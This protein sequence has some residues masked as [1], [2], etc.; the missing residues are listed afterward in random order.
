MDRAHFVRGDVLAAV[1]AGVAAAACADAEL[2]GV[3]LALRGRGWRRRLGRGRWRRRDVVGERRAILGLGPDKVVHVRDLEALWDVRA[4]G[5]TK[6]HCGSC[7]DDVGATG[8]GA[9]VLQR[10]EAICERR[11]RE[12]QR[13]AG[14]ARARRGRHDHTWAN[15]S[16]KGIAGGARTHTERQGGGLATDTELAT[17]VICVLALVAPKFGGVTDAPLIHDI[18]VEGREV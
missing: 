2:V 9:Q 8:A 17:F 5:R 11:A 14:E 7:A 4:P 6:A 13:E 10:A 15:G 1:K 18:Y 3:K 12:E 16:A